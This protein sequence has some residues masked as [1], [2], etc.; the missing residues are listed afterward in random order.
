MLE[1][2]AQAGALQAR[3]DVRPGWMAKP[4]LIGLLW[5]GRSGEPAGHAFLPG[6]DG[7][8]IERTDYRN[9]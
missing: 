8:E 4:A 2:I 5:K 7:L 3:H 1:V 9:P 6:H